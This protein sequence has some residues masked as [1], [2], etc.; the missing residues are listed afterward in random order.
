[1]ITLYAYQ[2]RSRAE[3]VL[4]L[5]NELNLNYR[6]IRTTPLEIK[7]FNPLGKVPAIEHNGQ[8]YTESLAIMEY[9]VSLTSRGDLIPQ[10]NEDIYR[11]RNFIYYLLSEVESYLWIAT[12]ASNLKGFYS[13]P[14]GT[15]AE[16]IERVKVNIVFLFEHLTCYNYVCSDFTIADIYAYH[17]FTWARTHGIN[18]PETVSEYLQKLEERTSFPS[19]MKG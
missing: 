13:W 1:M 11:F 19:E 16:S 9:L 15:Y 3:R 12:Q 17:V 7:R 10:N 4:W 18:I 5:L 8:L 2:F 6:V 14:E